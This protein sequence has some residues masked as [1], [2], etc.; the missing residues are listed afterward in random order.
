MTKAVSEDKLATFFKDLMTKNGGSSKEK[1][2]PIEGEGEEE[3]PD[4]LY[5]VQYRDVGGR[6][7]DSKPFVVPLLIFS[8]ANLSQLVKATSHWTSR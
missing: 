2:Q 5:V 1:E 8:V 6:V 4:V 7:V 3:V